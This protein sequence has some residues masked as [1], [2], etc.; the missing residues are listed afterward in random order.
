MLAYR[1]INPY[2]LETVSEHPT[3]ADADLDQVIARSQEAFHS[4]WGRRTVASRAEVLRRAA[5]MLDRDVDRHARTITL[6]MGKL[7]GEVRD[8]VR[9][10]AAILRYYGDNAERLLA[11]VA[12]DT[13]LAR[14]RRSSPG[15]SARSSA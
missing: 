13:G 10:T 9:L 15:R 11:P 1:S 4:D 8:E 7:I 3:I 2:S 5:D 12:V 14:R 6:E